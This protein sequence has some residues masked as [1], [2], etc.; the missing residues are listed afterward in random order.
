[1]AYLRSRSVRSNAPDSLSLVSENFFTAGEA[2]PITIPLEKVDLGAVTFQSSV[3]HSLEDLQLLLA[4]SK[5]RILKKIFLL[6]IHTL[7]A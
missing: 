7:K 2:I 1:M 3:E 5:F 4:M 6:I